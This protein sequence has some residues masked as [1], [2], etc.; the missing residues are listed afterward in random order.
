MYR[1]PRISACLFGIL[2][3]GLA[4]AR[5]QS[6]QDLIDQMQAL[7]YRNW[8][9]PNYP[10]P[11]YANS[12]NR[13]SHASPSD[14]EN[15][16][17][18][19]CENAGN[20]DAAIAHYR[21]AYQL[22][23]RDKTIRK[24]LAGAVSRSGIALW[25]NGDTGAA[26][27]L[28]QEALGL[29]PKNKDYRLNVIWCQASIA[30]R[31][32]DYSTALA[33]YREALKLDPKNASL[34][35]SF[36][37]TENNLGVAC[38]NRG[39]WAGAIGYYQQALK[40]FPTVENARNNLQIAQDRLAQ[41]EAQEA[42]QRDDALVAMNA[43][44]QVGQLASAFAPPPPGFEEGGPALSGDES[45]PFASPDA[46]STDPAWGDSSV[47]D[48]RDKQGIVNR[49][50][51]QEGSPSPE[52]ELIVA[53]PAASKPAAQAV[54][55]LEKTRQD[56]KG[57]QKALE[58][59]QKS[60]AGDASQ[61]EEWEK[62]SAKASRDA[63]FTA[64]DLALTMLGDHLD[65]QLK[66]NDE[67]LTHV[68]DLLISETSDPDRREQLELAFKA[69]EERKDELLSAQ[70]AVDHG[71]DVLKIA[72]TATDF[73]HGDAEPENPVEIAYDACKK[74]QDGFPPEV[75]PF[76][77]K[78]TR[79]VDFGRV[80]IDGCY[81]ACVQAASVSRIS[82]LNQ[83]SE[84]YLKAVATLSDRM[85]TLVKLENG[86]VQARRAENPGAPRS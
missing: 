16:A 33:E 31:N 4:S 18:V 58:E 24:N 1:L 54:D 8:G 82:Q 57:V 3:I 76:V 49:D 65:Q 5:S 43:R 9:Y 72:Q 17:G 70:E 14:Q 59:L 25:R 21:R 32:Q 34:R 30:F 71:A 13:V 51:L 37:S 56:I 64:G 29:F 81:E 69:L 79:P 39:D 85:K 80:A 38:A 19:D 55:P 73:A 75:Q 74:L 2:A 15:N 41:A 10:H 11:N 53:Q 27:A 40:D 77:D 68:D 28:L 35:E 60:M 62:E 22:D 84:S 61:R 50:V 78:V 46:D 86:L 52:G 42:F 20:L 7:K 44:L 23:P 83:N 47:V 12:A 45:L 6:A 48:L 63:Y 67:E 26:L 66:A 36:A